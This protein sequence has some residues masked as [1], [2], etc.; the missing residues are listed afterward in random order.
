MFGNLLRLV[1]DAEFHA[2]LIGNGHHDALDLNSYAVSS[3]T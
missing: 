1:C 3:L 2:G